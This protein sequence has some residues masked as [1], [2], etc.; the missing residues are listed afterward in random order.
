MLY[1]ANYTEISKKKDNDLSTFADQ[2]ITKIKA[3]DRYASI[4]TAFETYESSGTAYIKAFTNAV[5]GSKEQKRTKDQARI[6]FLASAKSFCLLLGAN[7]E[8]DQT[9]ITDAGFPL[10]KERSGS[11]SPTFIDLPLNIIVKS[12]AKGSLA[13]SFKLVSRRDVRVTEVRVSLD[14]GETWL[15]STFFANQKGYIT[16]LP[17]VKEAY[18]SLRNIGVNSLVSA[19]TTPT[20]VTII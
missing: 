7:S 11:V 2:T 1:K 6:N 18:V 17:S 10:M 15:E 3:N 19:W 16:G 5:N 8:N 9:Y 12:N 20:V 4:A 14:A 13:I